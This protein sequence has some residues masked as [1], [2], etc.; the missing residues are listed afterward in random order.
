M[1]VQHINNKP[2]SFKAYATIIDKEKM[3]N[4]TQIKALKEMIKGIGTPTDIVQLDL[5]RSTN[6][7]GLTRESYTIS[8]MTAINKKLT[9]TVF[10]GYQGEVSEIEKT[11]YSINR[12]HEEFFGKETN[13][14]IPPKSI[15]PFTLAQNIIK[16]MCHK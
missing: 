11:I 16:E 2:T 5:S 9:H 4:W 1:K 14:S 7:H 8:L 13:P 6:H 12:N 10:K 3:L 15:S